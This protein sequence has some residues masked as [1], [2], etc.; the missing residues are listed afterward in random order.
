MAITTYHTTLHCTS[1]PDL[2]W[3]ENHFYQISEDH[4][5][6]MSL[7]ATSPSVPVS[8]INRDKKLPH[9]ASNTG[10]IKWTEKISYD[11][12]YEIINKKLKVKKKKRKVQNMVFDSNNPQVFEGNRP[13]KYGDFP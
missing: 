13:M 2:E 4:I 3:I 7:E 6:E 1:F 10:Q 8:P 5:L 11:K 12:A 9:Q